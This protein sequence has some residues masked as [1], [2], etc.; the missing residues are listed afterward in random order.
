MWPPVA[1]RTGRSADPTRPRPDHAHP[2]TANSTLIFFTDGLIE[3][4]AHSLDTGLDALTRLAAD[5][6]T[7]SLEDLVETLADH[8]PGDGHD[9]LAILALRTP[10]QPPPPA[11]HRTGR[12][13]QG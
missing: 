5:Q 7:E 6:V 11:T 3:H 9:D 1:P 4:R 8:H 12:A 13:P 10:A 2:L